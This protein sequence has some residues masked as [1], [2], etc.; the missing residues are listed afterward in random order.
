ML[1]SPTKKR[2]IH[3]NISESVISKAQQKALKQGLYNGNGVLW[4]VIF[5][6]L[7]EK[8]LEEPAK[9][10]MKEHGEYK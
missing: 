2:S 7:L 5:E 1:K 6:Q 8:Y 4:G 9:K 10:C 3:C